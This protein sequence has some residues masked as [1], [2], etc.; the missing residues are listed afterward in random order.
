MSF[1]QNNSVEYFFQRTIESL[2]ISGK[3]ERTAETYAREVRIMG[4]WL[5]KP[6]DQAT[7]EDVRRFYLYRLIDK[8]L[9][10][11]SMR[12]LICG[13]RELFTTVLG[14]EWPVLEHMHTKRLQKLPIVI[15]RDEVWKIIDKS[16]NL[17]HRTYLTLV[18]TCGLRLSEAVKITVHDIDGRRMRIH[19]RQG[20]GG[21]DRYVPLP[22]TTYLLLKQYWPTHH[23]PRFLFPA[24]GRG[25]QKG[26]TATKPM[27]TITVQGG[28]RRA[29]EAAA[30]YRPG[31]RIHTLR[32]CFATHLLEAGI[33]IHAIQR[34]MGHSD[35]TTTLRYF[36]LTKMGQIDNEKILNDI[37]NDPKQEVKN[38]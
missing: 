13:I 15:E 28:L 23:N 30:L 18:Y 20:K 17:C 26:F 35:L 36:H 25:G 1:Y 21:K 5:N 19:I 7:A 11:V 22:R 24:L 31:L 32:H 8:K 27:P 6:L 14:K 37:M 4:R 34:Y 9:S 16:D 10:D 3:S 12:I 29:A 33:N 38:A 2:R